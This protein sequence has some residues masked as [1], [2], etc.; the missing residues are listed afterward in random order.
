MYHAELRHAIDAPWT[1]M[2]PIRVG[3]VPSF[4]GTTGAYVTVEHDGNPLARIDVWPLTAGPFTEVL[5]WKTF[6]VLGWGCHVHLIDPLT[7]DVRSFDCDQYFGH[8]YQFHDR[9]LIADASRLTCIDIR[10]D[11]LWQSASMGIDG[12]V[13]DEMRD[14]LILGQGE[15]DPPGGW[16]PF[17]LSLETGRDF[18]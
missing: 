13:V 3:P 6:V 1:A 17:R 2:E 16:K 12:V 7:R 5:A 8:L 14:G 15:W 11:R 18:A 4:P 10:G 9:M